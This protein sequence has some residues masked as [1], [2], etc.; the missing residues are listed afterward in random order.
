VVSKTAKHHRYGDAELLRARDLQADYETEGGFLWRHTAALHGTWGI[1][2]GMT[3][4]L[5]ENLQSVRV[6]SGLA[7]DSQGQELLSAETVEV[8]LPANLTSGAGDVSARDP[9]V[10]D[11]VASVGDRAAVV[12]RSDSDWPGRLQLTWLRPE[13]V[14]GGQEVRLVRATV[15]GGLIRQLH[16]QVRRYVRPLARPYMAAGRTPPG[17]RWERWSVSSHHLGWKMHVDTSAAGFTLVPHY[18]V[19]LARDVLAEQ[20]RLARSLAGPFTSVW[21]PR[22]DGFTLVVVFAAPSDD[23][24]KTEAKSLGELFQQN[25]PQVDWLGIEPKAQDGIVRGSDWSFPLAVLVSPASEG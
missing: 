18:F 14:R 2:Q 15:D 4:R 19:S 1:A 9:L 24:A 25:A 11:L 3:V 10:L 12:R 7:Y 8:A 5:T 20:S 13:E 21:Q 22:P 16:T 17:T 23:A 6:T